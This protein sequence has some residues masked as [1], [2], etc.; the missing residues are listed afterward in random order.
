MPI[1][2]AL[3]KAQKHRSDLY[4]FAKSK[5]LTIHWDMKTKKMEEIVNAF[6]S[7]KAMTIVKAF[8]SSKLNNDPSTLKVI[9]TTTGKVNVSLSRFN[10]IRKQIVSPADKKLLIHIKGS[11]GRIAKSYHLN[12]RVVNINNLFI[13]EENQY[14]SGAD[15]ELNIL[16][17]TTIETEWLPNSKRSRSE[18]KNFFRYLPKA[19][20]NLEAFQ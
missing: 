12:D 15:I 20:Y 2:S 7:K 1:S 3:K 17:T 11:D 16:P 5:N 4:R 19:D 8:K 9:N 6:K 13:D 14:S 18:R 10:R